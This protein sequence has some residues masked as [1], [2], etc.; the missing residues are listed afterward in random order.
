MIPLYKRTGKS[1][2]K[3]IGKVLR[4]KELSPLGVEKVS[5]SQCMR[6]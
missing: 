2:E 4:D 5:A 6:L 3:V 1:G